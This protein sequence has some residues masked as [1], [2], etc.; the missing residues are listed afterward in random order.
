MEETFFYEDIDE[1]LGPP[2]ARLYRYG[3]GVLLLALLILAGVAAGVHYREGI[4]ATAF[5]PGAAGYSGAPGSYFVK[6]ALAPGT[7]PPP[8]GPLPMLTGREVT[9]VVHGPDGRPAWH[10]VAVIRSEPYLDSAGRRWMVDAAFAD[11]AAAAAIIRRPG[12]R[13]AQAGVFIVTGQR[14]L[15]SRLFR[16]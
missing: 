3:S 15:L 5:V 9:L 4:S 2:P 16:F 12:F 7:Y 11:T 10:G 6:I 13:G 14:S 8:V 1:V